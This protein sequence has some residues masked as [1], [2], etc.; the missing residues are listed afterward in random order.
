MFCRY[1]EKMV[2]CYLN[3]A[4]VSLLKEREKNSKK[5][6]RCISALI[7]HQKEKIHIAVL[8]T[9]THYNDKSVCYSTEYIKEKVLS[10]SP[11]DG[12]AE[13][14]CFEA[15]P[16]YFQKEM[17][18]CI[19]EKNLIAQNK[20]LPDEYKKESIFIFD[21]GRFK[22]KPGTSFHLLIT[23]PPCGW[24]RNKEKPRMQW[25]I[26]FKKAPHVPKCSSKILI[27]SVMGIQGY[28]SHLLD[29]CIFVKSVVILCANKDVKT[30]P[31]EYTVGAQFPLVL[32]DISVMHYDAQ[33]FNPNIIT[34][35][36]MHLMQEEIESNKAIN[37][38]NKGADQNNIN[39]HKLNGMD[40][41]GHKRSVLVAGQSDT[42]STFFNYTYNP[43]DKDEKKREID[44][45]TLIK[46]EFSIVERKV[47]RRLLD[48]VDLDFQATRKE[49][50]KKKFDDLQDMLKATDAL[51]DLLKELYEQKERYNKT[52]C[53][54][55]GVEPNR[56]DQAS[57]HRVDPPFD[58]I[59]ERF[60][61]KTRE[62]VSGEFKSSQ[63][64][65][66]EIDDFIN[67]VRGYQAEGTKLIDSQRMIQDVEKIL[68][69][70]LDV[71]I[72][73]SWKRYFY[74]EPIS[75]QES[76][77][78]FFKFLTLQCYFVYANM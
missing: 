68:N 43:C 65:D 6:H 53:K 30:G 27:N 45:S 38:L 13:S 66:K 55:A 67:K 61:R 34:F 75:T 7:C 71:T 19:E 74:S 46:K 60:E 29:E 3:T 57:E 59:A 21:K 25:K 41:D 33:R 42:G 17:L 56:V 70:K 20:N 51:R 37:K 32:P 26:N 18:K 69:E 76:T 52:V 50:M 31:L 16:I 49:K 44:Y 77:T 12:H 63:V 9:G 62:L 28:V 10:N 40:E 54:K 22:L 23:E 24:I 58:S 2:D 39:I 78:Y 35:E 4:G 48:E 8:C 47:D 5:C 1:L 14:L 64:W 36:P 11:C 72:D 73:C 15:A